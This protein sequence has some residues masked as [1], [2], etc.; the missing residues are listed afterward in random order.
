MNEKESCTLKFPSDEKNTIIVHWSKNGRE[1][2]EESRT[3]FCAPWPTM[4]NSN[5]DQFSGSELP[6]DA[7]ERLWHKILWTGVYCITFLRARKNTVR[8]PSP[9][10]N[11]T[12]P[13]TK[14]SHQKKPRGTR[15]INQTVQSKLF[16]SSE[17]LHSC[18]RLQL[19]YNTLTTGMKFCAPSVSSQTVIVHVS[20]K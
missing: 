5:V 6:T 11:K 17:E 10:E 15:F 13:T 8:F 4:S 2:Q 16:S 18:T 19:S 12:K 14:N 20:M 9:M 7:S 3:Q 1:K